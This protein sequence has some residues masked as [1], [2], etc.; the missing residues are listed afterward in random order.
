MNFSELYKAFLLSFGHPI[1]YR[2]WEGQLTDSQCRV[3]SGFISMKHNG[4]HIILLCEVDEVYMQ[5]QPLA[6]TCW[7]TLTLRRLAGMR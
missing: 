4:K 1:L 7:R 2:L 3:G 5:C 6:Y